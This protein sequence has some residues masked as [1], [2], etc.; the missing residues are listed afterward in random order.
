M[1]VSPLSIPQ[2]HVL[3]AFI[4]PIQVLPKMRVLNQ[5]L[6]QAYRKRP[7][8]LHP[9]PKVVRRKRTAQGENRIATAIPRYMA[10]KAV[11]CNIQ[12]SKEGIKHEI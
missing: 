2:Y 5:S 8:L 4:I 11:L 6:R 10:V 7:E 1:Y 12:K 3:P 9:S